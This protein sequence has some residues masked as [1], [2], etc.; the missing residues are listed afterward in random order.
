MTKDSLA[1]APG[2]H[3]AKLAFRKAQ[4]LAQRQKKKLFHSKNPI[5]A[6]KKERQVQKVIARK[7]LPKT[8]ATPGSDADLLMR[9][10]SSRIHKI[11]K[12][13]MFLVK[14]DKYAVRDAVEALRAYH[15]E[16]TEQKEHAGRRDDVVEL[17]I[18]VS[19]V[20]AKVTLKPIKVPVVHPLHTPEQRGLTCL[21]HKDN[22]K[23][24]EAIKEF[25]SANRVQVSHGNHAGHVYQKVR[26][27]VEGRKESQGHAE[28]LGLHFL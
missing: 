16:F 28:V 22:D 8:S 24:V 26:G 27:D 19:K 2:D 13:T 21:L 15:A 4:I 11:R 14:L 6:S 10:T 7:N 1:S 25:C 3:K 20:L 18:T 17:V 12:Q 9:E 23:R 5:L